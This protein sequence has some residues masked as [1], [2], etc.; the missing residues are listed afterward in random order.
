MTVILMVLRVVGIALL[1]ILGFLLTAV[2]AVLFVPVRYR[3]DGS[4]HEELTASARITWLLHLLSVRI[5]FEKELN[6]KA[7][8]CGVQIYP[9]AARV[10]KQSRL[11]EHGGS[12]GQED[13]RKGTTKAPEAGKTAESAKPAETEK[14]TGPGKPAES[15]KLTEPA[16]TLETAG[17]SVEETGGFEEADREAAG[18]GGRTGRKVLSPGDMADRLKRAFQKLQDSLRDIRGMIRRLYERFS[19]YKSVWDRE[20]TRGAFRLASAQ[21]SK[22][23]RHVLPRRTDIYAVIGTGNPASTGQILAVQGMLYPWLGDKVHIVPDFEEEH[24]EGGFHLRGH[25]RV[26]V[27]GFYGLR[28]MFDRDVRHFIGILRGRTADKEENNGRKQRQ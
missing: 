14:P 26:G 11:Q 1:V 7:F 27:L 5:I 16:K 13:M 2:F 3:A 28:L 22:T 21:L 4:F 23:M 12:E 19:Y 18:M 20:E 10:K 17:D 6:V 15:E 8:V 24:F 25:I 9:R